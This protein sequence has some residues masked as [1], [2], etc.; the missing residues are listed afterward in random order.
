MKLRIYNKTLDPNI[1]NEDK[2]IKSEVRDS[3]L[4]IAEDFYNSTELDGELHDILFIGSSANYNWTPTSDIDLHLVIDIAEEKINEDYAR[5]FMDSLGFKWNTEHDIEMKGHPV[6]VYIQDIREPNSNAQLSREGAAIYSLFDGKWLQEPTH[7]KID[8]DSDKIRKKFQTIQQ[9]AKKLVE[10]SDIEKLKELMKSIRNYRDTGLAKGG[11]FCTENLVFKALRKTGVLEQIKKTINDVYDKQVS[12]PEHG[13]MQ[14][15]TDTNPLNE[16]DHSV[17]DLIKMFA[18]HKDKKPF[19]L[20]GSINKDGD[21]FSM[22][23]YNNN[24]GHRDLIGYR[25]G[26][27]RWRYNSIKNTVYWDTWGA[28][29]GSEE[30]KELVD[31]HINKKY[32]VKNPKHILSGKYYTHGHS[33]DENINKDY[34]VVGWINND[35]EIISEKDLVGLGNVT[36]DLVMKHNPQFNDGNWGN[37]IQW[38][39]KSKNNTIYWY[40]DAPE[41]QRFAVAEYLK[42]KYNIKNPRQTHTLDFSGHRIDELMDKKSNLFLGFVNREN[43]KVIGTSVDSEDMTHERWSRTLPPEQRWGFGTESLLWRYK[44]STN[45]VYW[46]ATFDGPN[47]EEKESVD[48]WLEKNVNIKYPKHVKMDYYRQKDYS[49]DFSGSDDDDSNDDDD[50]R[51]DAHKIDESLEEL[52]SL[53]ESKD[54]ELF[55][56]PLVG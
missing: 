45:T 2:T 5:K 44:R 7:E 27:L 8:F 25:A 40:E 52:M 29:M 41:Q 49:D 42:E 12:L 10:T 26:D 13:N 9:K 34:L 37:L 24:L 35:L 15:S 21:I 17:E 28:G 32:G 16:N 36:H 51:M 39:Y 30:S 20:V 48:Y 1:W 4:K 31:H 38:R 43:F 14:P 46:W 3:L 50:N 6:E 54:S 53:M 19:T 33:V 47:E 22:K 11:E 55:F 18:K 23:D 56:K